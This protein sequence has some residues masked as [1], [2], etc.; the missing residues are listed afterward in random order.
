MKI[1]SMTG[2]QCKNENG[3]EYTILPD[4][5]VQVKTDFGTFYGR[6]IEAVAGSNYIV[7]DCSV[8]FYSDVKRINFTQIKEIE[9]VNS[10][11]KSY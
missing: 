7:L 11:S 4:T 1:T 3:N 5:I 2:I 9:V 8:V 10:E 6:F